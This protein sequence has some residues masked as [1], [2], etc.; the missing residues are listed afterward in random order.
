MAARSSTKSNIASANGGN[1]G[2]APFFADDD[3]E[4]RNS[5]KPSFPE[6][7]PVVYL[8][9][10]EKTWGY[11]DITSAI[12]NVDPSKELPYVKTIVDSNRDR[13]GFAYAV[14]KNWEDAAAVAYQINIRDGLTATTETGP[15]KCMPDAEFRWICPDFY[16]YLK[17]TH[18]V[19]PKPPKKCE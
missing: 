10:L 19:R 14:Y 13:T 8:S 12:R 4:F 11:S 7:I 3:H 1:N 5:W 9:N 15:V 2:S 6:L 17:T 18:D 16:L